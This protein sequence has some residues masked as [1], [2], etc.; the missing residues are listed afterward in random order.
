VRVVDDFSQIAPFDVVEPDVDGT[1]PPL[2][3]LVASPHSGDCYPADFLAA[4]RLDRRR[5]RRSEDAFVDRL[6][7]AAPSCGAALLKANFPRAF[8]DV[9]REPYE[10]DPRMFVGRLPA[11]ANIRSLR[12]SGGLGTIARV[13]AENE[14][15]Y[16]G[17]IPVE[18]ALD[19]IATFYFPYHDALAA[20]LERLRRARGFAVLLDCHSM[21]SGI[22]FIDTP[23][24]V[25]IVVGDRYG[26]SADPGLVEAA[27]TL[28]ETLGFAVL[29]NKPYAGGYITEHYGRPTT[30]IHA[31]QIEIN[32]GLYMDEARHLPLPS[33]DAVAGRLAAF[34]KGFA[35]VVAAMATPDRLAA[36]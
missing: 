26:A 10:L 33:F 20:R 4:S 15:I 29:R 1:A 34:L 8:L 9:N 17:P 24:R 12:V 7:A 19:R 31:I 14:E 27:M 35:A 16:A 21:P 30:G 22:R 13:V 3:L 11:H 28:F 18:A 23:R 25:D 32:R 2:P 36:E 6:F 5:I